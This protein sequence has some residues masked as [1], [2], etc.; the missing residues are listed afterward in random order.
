MSKY[1]RKPVKKQGGIYAII[2]NANG[3]IYIG[4]TNDLPRRKQKHFSLLRNNKHSNPLLQNAYNK[5]GEQA[6]EF[7][8]IENCKEGKLLEREQ[9]YIY[10]YNACNKLS[11]FNLSV[12]ADKP[13]L[14]KEGRES[15]IQHNRKYKHLLPE[16][17]RLHKLG[18]S[19][20]KIARLLKVG[21]GNQTI[22]ERY[23]IR[24]GYKVDNCKERKEAVYKEIVSK[25][26]YLRNESGLSLKKISKLYKV[27]YK[28]LVKY[29]KENYPE[30]YNP[31]NKYKDMIP[32]WIELRKQGKTFKAIAE[33]YGISSWATVRWNLLNKG[34]N[35]VDD[36]FPLCYNKTIIV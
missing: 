4:S 28:R 20:L 11:G 12:R 5:Y 2:C 15:T 18:Y 22:V 8:V 7:R 30:L 17:I 16:F 29:L 25:W 23:L 19:T 10:Y 27:G 14:T 9:Y 33:Q 32:E 26:Q 35:T 1:K 3:K 36:I 6:F 21:N 31:E 34:N 13:V 24:A